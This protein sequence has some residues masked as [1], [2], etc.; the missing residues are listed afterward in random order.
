MLRVRR[1]AAV[2]EET[3]FPPGPER[4]DRRL[5]HRGDDFRAL[6]LKTGHR[7]SVIGKGVLNES[8]C[9]HESGFSVEVMESE[10]DSAGKIQGDRGEQF[11]HRLVDRE[12]SGGIVGGERPTLAR[13]VVAQQ[14]AVGGKLAR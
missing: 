10:R 5:A 13:D 6:L 7:R 11:V 14:R 1:T 8:G 2:A 9:G 3:D 4:G 12:E